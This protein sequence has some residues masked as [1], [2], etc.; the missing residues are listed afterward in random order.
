M[1]KTLP[2]ILIG[3]L[4]LIVGA[5]AGG[6]L[7]LII[8]G[9]F[10]GAFDIYEQTGLQGYEVTTYIG[11]VMGAIAGIIISLGIVKRRNL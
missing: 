10:L 8:G 5:I 11:L 4:A 3:F 7:G 2:K 9:T 1:K 6:Y